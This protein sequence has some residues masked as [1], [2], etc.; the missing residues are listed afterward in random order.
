M[1]PEHIPLE[2]AEKI[3]FIGE[4]IL[5]FEGESKKNQGNFTKFIIHKVFL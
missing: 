4:S 3:I 5:E 1:L 2:I